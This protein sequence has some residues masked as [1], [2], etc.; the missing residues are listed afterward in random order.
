MSIFF[1]FKMF[2]VLNDKFLAFSTLDTSAL[3]FW[4]HAQLRFKISLVMQ[5]PKSQKEK[6]KKSPFERRD[7]FQ[8]DEG[9]YIGAFWRV[10][11]APKI[12]KILI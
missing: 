10:G 2:G 6:K 7:S 4:N 1:F 8:L 3:R 11:G 12:L 5:L 9:F